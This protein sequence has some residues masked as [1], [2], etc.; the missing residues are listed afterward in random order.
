MLEAFLRPHI[1]CVKQLMSEVRN[2]MS[3][4]SLSTKAKRGLLPRNEQRGRAGLICRDGF[5]RGAR[6]DKSW[7]QF[8]FPRHSI[9]PKPQLL[10]A[11]RHLH[12]RS[13]HKTTAR[14]WPFLFWQLQGALRCIAKCAAAA[15][16]KMSVI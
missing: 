1:S 13:R 10:A 5:Q 3:Q 14:D 16:R 4:V 9:A 11:T 6:R 2:R 15:G 12:A 7:L 8:E